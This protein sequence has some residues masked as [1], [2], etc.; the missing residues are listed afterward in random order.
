[1]NIKDTKLFF[2]EEDCIQFFD[3]DKGEEIFLSAAKLYEEL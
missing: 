3:A 2:L 1:M